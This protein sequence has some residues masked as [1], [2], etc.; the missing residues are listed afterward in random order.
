MWIWRK[1]LWSWCNNLHIRT[2]KNAET[3]FPKSTVAFGKRHYHGQKEKK[4][5]QE[6]A[7][8]VTPAKHSV[9]SPWLSF[10]FW[11]QEWRVNSRDATD[12]DAKMMQRSAFAIT[13]WWVWCLSLLVDTASYPWCPNCFTSMETSPRAEKVDSPLHSARVAFGLG[14]PWLCD[15]RDAE[16]GWAESVV[17]QKGVRALL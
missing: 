14:S 11:E 5:R 3:D 9:H 13:A 2:Q 6:Q 4:F 15:T 17:V 1:I 7:I 8:L 16:S 10:I 12:S